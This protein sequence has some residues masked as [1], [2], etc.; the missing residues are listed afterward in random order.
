MQAEEAGLGEAVQAEEAKVSAGGTEEAGAV[1]ESQAG[2]AV[3][4]RGEGRGKGAE[5]AREAG[6]GRGTGKEERGDESSRLANGGD[7][8]SHLEVLRSIL[9]KTA[10][11]LQLKI[12]MR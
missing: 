3:E 10:M 9:L 7:G 2:E 6:E 11:L 5:E 1:K 8:S 12:Y 4:G